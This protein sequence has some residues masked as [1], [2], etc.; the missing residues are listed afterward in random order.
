MAKLQFFHRLM[1]LRLSAAVLASRF[2]WLRFFTDHAAR[3][4]LMDAFDADQGKQEAPVKAV[5]PLTALDVQGR[6]LKPRAEKVRLVQ[7]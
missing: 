2:D 7:N 4:E 3:L 5:N 1:V 6:R